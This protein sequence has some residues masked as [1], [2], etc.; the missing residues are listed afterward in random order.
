[1]ALGIPTV[2]TAIGANFRII[3]NGVSGFLVN[4]E[5][6]WIRALSNLIENAELRKQMGMAA[7]KRV[8]ELYSIKA[9]TKKYMDV[10]ESVMTGRSSRTPSL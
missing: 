5:K 9:N 3:E 6:E 10:I 1:M 7:R 4:S 8:T 2:A